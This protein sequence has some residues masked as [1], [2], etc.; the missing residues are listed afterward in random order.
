MLA[1]IADR[2]QPTRVFG[3]AYVPTPFYFY[4]RIGDQDYYRKFLTN[5]RDNAN[6]PGEPPAYLCDRR[7]HG[8]GHHLGRFRK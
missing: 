6:A 7:L 4:K 8:D 2:G 3:S 5:Y 1:V